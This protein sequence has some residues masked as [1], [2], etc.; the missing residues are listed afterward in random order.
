MKIGSEKNRGRVILCQS[1][2]Q[3]EI[4]RIQINDLFEGFICFLSF[5]AKDGSY[6]STNLVIILYSILQ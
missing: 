4:D 2:L 6:L 3:V 1:V 5:V